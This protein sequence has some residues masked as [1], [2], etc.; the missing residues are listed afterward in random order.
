MVLSAEPLEVCNSSRADYSNDNDNV[1]GATVEFYNA[2]GELVDQAM[3]QG[4]VTSG[5]DSEATETSGRGGV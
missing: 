3:Y 1:S 5:L 2:D 4:G